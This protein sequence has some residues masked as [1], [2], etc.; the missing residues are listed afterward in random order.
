MAID[1]GGYGLRMTHDS[2]KRPVGGPG[3]FLDRATIKNALKNERGFVGCCHDATYPCHIRVTPGTCN[4][5]YRYENSISM[6][7]D[8][9]SHMAWTVGI[10]T[11]SVSAIP[12]DRACNASSSVGDPCLH[13]IE[14]KSGELPKM[15]HSSRLYKTSLLR[16]AASIP[17]PCL[18]TFNLPGEAK[19]ADNYKTIRRG[20]ACYRSRVAKRSQIYIVRDSEQY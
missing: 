20:D 19:R 9:A 12:P 6:P 15:K 5:V 14:L 11:G 1:R 17:T 2:K 10:K 8:L 16:R 4:R 13:M 18:P 7:R 3:C